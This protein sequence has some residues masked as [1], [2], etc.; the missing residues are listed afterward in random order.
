MQG[1]IFIYLRAQYSGE[2]LSIDHNP[3]R[4]PMP[5]WQYRVHPQTSN[6][7]AARPFTGQ[8]DTNRPLPQI[9]PTAID[10]S[11]PTLHPRRRGDS[12]AA[13]AKHGRSFSHPFPSFF[14]G[15]TRRAEKRNPLKNTINVDSTDEDDSTGDGRPQQSSNTPSRKPSINAGG[16]PMIGRCMACDSTVRWPRDLKVFRCTICLTV[17]DLEPY[18]DTNQQRPGPNQNNRHP[19]FAVPRKRTFTLKQWRYEQKAD[20]L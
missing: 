11:V 7:P 19:Q 8:T 17:N 5:P 20:G 14:G 10:L 16:E 13:S 9:S 12:D 4:I 18:L 15:G 3:L 1:P 2:N 6:A